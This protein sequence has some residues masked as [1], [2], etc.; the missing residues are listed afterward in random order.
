MRSKTV[1]TELL[2]IVVYLYDIH[3]TRNDYHSF[4]NTLKN[5]F[6]NAVN[7]IVPPYAVLPLILC[8]I[9]NMLVYTGSQ[10]LVVGRRHYDFTSTW[11]NLI[12]LVPGWTL[13]YLGCFLI[14][15]V[16]YILVCREN[17]VI[18]YE[19]LS[20]EALSK[21]ICGVFFIFLPTTNVRPELVGSDC[22][23]QLLR[24][25]YTVDQPVNLFPSIHCLAIW[26]SWRGLIKCEKVSRFYKYISFLF[27]CLV[28]LSVLYTKQHIL[29]DI[30]GGVVVA[31][32]G[33]YLSGKL[34]LGDVY[35]WMNSRIN[36]A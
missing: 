23:T 36:I 28:F 32:I 34:H 12:P 25:V 1:P 9:I 29:I 11:D 6:L 16:N 18:C 10:F 20:A 27:V 35:K 31:E 2:W 21:L 26:Y 15:I 30:I 3:L 5:T 17:R 4:M 19:F 33:W 24:F 13:V 7:K 22:F 8:P 14:W